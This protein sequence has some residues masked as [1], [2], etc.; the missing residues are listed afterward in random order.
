M[1]KLLRPSSFFLFLL[2]FC[3]LAQNGFAQSSWTGAAQFPTQIHVVK[4]LDAQGAPD[5][6]FVGTDSAIYYSNNTGATWTQATIISP[7][8]PV[9]AKPFPSGWV[10]DITFVDSLNGFAVVDSV[11]GNIIP[12]AGILKTTNGGTTWTFDDNAGTPDSGCGIYYDA[13]SRRLF[14]S[15]LDRGLVVSTDTGHT[16]SVIDSGTWYTGFAFNGNGRGVVATQGST[17]VSAPPYHTVYWLSTTDDGVTWHPT[18][19]STQ[20]WQPAGVPTTETFFG[21][22]DNYC[23]GSDMQ[24]L[25]SDNSGLGFSPLGGYSGLNDTLNQSMAGDGCSLFAGSHTKANG[26]WFSVNDG[27][28]WQPS[29]GA[30][31]PPVNTRFYVSP[32]TMWSFGPLLP[33]G[34]FDSL[35]SAAR[36]GTADIHIWPDT[37]AFKNAACHN[38]SDTTIHIFGCNCKGLITLTGDSIHHFQAGDSAGMQVAFNPPPPQSLCSG[39]LGVATSVGIGFQ[40]VSPIADT[41]DFHILLNDNGRSVDTV[42]HMT[43][44]G[45]P[46][47]LPSPISPTQSISLAGAACSGT[48]DTV[49]NF[50]NTTCETIQLQS[51]QVFESPECECQLQLTGACIINNAISGINLPP[52]EQF[53]FEIDYTPGLIR[54]SCSASFQ[55][56]Y[57]NLAG[58]LDTMTSP[59][60]INAST[61]TDL[62]PSFRG[63]NIKAKNCCPPGVPADTTI[64]FINTTC[65]TILLYTPIFGGPNNS[66]KN[67]T[68]DNSGPFHITFP[69]T[70]PPHNHVPLTIGIKCEGG[71]STAYVTFPYTISAQ[72]ASSLC[73]IGTN[74]GSYASDSLI[75]TITLDVGNSAMPEPE[76]SPSPINFGN[77]NCC[78]STEVKTITFTAGCKPDTITGITV[79]TSPAGNFYLVNTGL[80]FPI[81]FTAGQ[82]QTFQIGFLPRCGGGSGGMDTGSVFVYEGTGGLLRGQISATSNNLPSAPPSLTSLVFDSVE[83]CK[84]GSCQTDTLTNTSCGTVSVSILQPPGNPDFTAT[85]QGTV[86]SI[87]I[88][89]KVPL[90]C[91]LNP[92]AST[93]TGAISDFVILQVTDPSNGTIGIPDDTVFL[94]AYIDPPVPAYSVTPIPNATICDSTMTGESFTLT[95]NGTCY[96][97]TITSVTTG[98]SQV[99]VTP[100]TATI[101]TGNS[102]TFN[103]T[104][105]PTSVGVDSGWVVLHNSDG[106]TDSVH[107]YFADTNCEKLGTFTLNLPTNTSITQN[108]VNGVVVFNVDAGGGSGTVTSV[109]VTGSDRFSALNATGGA[110]PFA[111]SILYDPNPTGANSALVTIQYTIN[112]VPGVDTFSVYG[113]TTGSVGSAR[114]GVVTP[115]DTCIPPNGAALKEFDVM[116]YDSIPNSLGVNLLTFV[117]HYNGDLL[118]SPQNINFGPNWQF[119]SDSQ[120][121][122]GLHITLKYTGTGNGASA[123]G[124]A[125]IKITQLGAVSKLLSDTAII[126]SPHF[127]DSAFEACTMKALAAS[128]DSNAAPICIDTSCNAVLL[129]QDVRGNLQAVTGIQVIP[130]PTHKGGSTAS[131]HFTTHMDGNVTADVLDV[132]GHSVETLAGGSLETGDHAI[133]IPTDQLPEGTYFARVTVGG[134]TVI[135]QFVLE[136]E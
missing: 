21:A 121:S 126:T 136:K 7:N 83:I 102:K 2:L 24:I 20:T 50:V 59:V 55:I 110:M 94:S 43:A 68:L 122:D 41:A 4:F 3:A 95:N 39:G 96:T 47:I 18:K 130:N 119:V 45:I 63:F 91:C 44:N 14:V 65:D 28:I 106:T 100:D 9:P 8:N 16:W 37:F 5:K 128:G 58:T 23:Y 90:V 108:C 116:L 84:P 33:P 56:T 13:A 133:A 85:L 67:F 124:T 71:N 6:G 69:V 34:N 26:M 98:N 40:P 120:A 88:G 46:S 72:F 48:I 131:L 35:Y 103:I 135:R 29:V 10:N 81:Y 19:M 107:Y 86:N 38:T 115:A 61:T 17:C 80:T 31:N 25:R 74:C 12:D 125:L 77:V 53:Q 57:K 101:G 76:I 89:G 42:I 113:Q 64:Y 15:S 62:K 105:M 109:S 87:P 73:Q 129:M 82:S 112:G 11:T 118:F 132:L 70:L 30:P 93:A 78:D 36:P 111:D 79:T 134:A 51:C 66:D 54:G 52:G 75:D 60:N 117:I 27:V 104:F 99:T 22:T 123:A 114:I 127:N 1:K 97:Y 49:I 92:A 32:T